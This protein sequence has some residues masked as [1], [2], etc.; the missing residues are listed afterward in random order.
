MHQGDLAA[1]EAATAR[2]LEI[3]PGNAE[4]LSNLGQVQLRSFRVSPAIER[5]RRALERGHNKPQ[6]QTNLGAALQVAG[7]VDAAMDCFAQALQL[8][9]DCHLAERNSL[10]A[11]LNQPDWTEAERFDTHRPWRPPLETGGAAG[12]VCKYRP[13]RGAQIED[14]VCVVGFPRSSGGTQPVAADRQS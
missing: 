6:V 7:D 12:A 10:I 3:S 5:F 1:A 4:A 13:G 9:P 8:D 11:M 2:A 14:R